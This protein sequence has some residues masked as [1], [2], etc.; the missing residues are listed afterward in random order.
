VSKQSCG[1]CKW[2]EFEMTNHTQTR[3]KLDKVGQCKWPVPALVWPSCFR[4]VEDAIEH[5]RSYVT[6]SDGI[7]CPTWEA[8]LPT[9]FEAAERLGEPLGMTGPEFLA[10]AEGESE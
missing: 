9:I 4:K 8:K 7:T 5:R 10:K 1:T 3:I 6:P 2:G